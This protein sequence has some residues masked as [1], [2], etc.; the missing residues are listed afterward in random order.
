[1]LD[2]LIIKPY[3]KSLSR[4]R[5]YVKKESRRYVDNLYL[6]DNR[7]LYDTKINISL[8]YNSMDHIR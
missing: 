8:S 7:H 1:M 5:R 3:L 2:Q 4:L 6:L